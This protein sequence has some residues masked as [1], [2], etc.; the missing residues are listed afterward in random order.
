MACPDELT[1]DLWLADALPSDEA[2]AVA[3]HVDT[4][5]TCAAAEQA[6]TRSTAELHAALALDAEELAYLRAWGWPRRWRTSPAA[7]AVN[8][9]WIALAGVVA[10]FVAWWVA[11]PT[12]GFA[13]ATAAQV[14]VGTVLLNAALVFLFSLGQALFEL[15]RNPA[16]RPES[17][18][19]GAARAGAAGLAA[20]P[21]S[22]QEYT[23]MNFRFSF[24]ALVL[25]S[26]LL[27]LAVP[28]AAMAAEVR[29][30]TSAVVAPG[31]TV[32][33]DLFASGQTVTVA[34]RV[35]GDVYAIGQT[36][37][38]TGT[39][40]GDLIAAA[41]Q[42]VVDGTVNGNV[43]AAGAVDH[44]QWPSG[45]QR[46]GSGPAGQH[47]LQWPRRRQP[48]RGRRDHQ[49]VRPGRSRDHRRR[50]H[51][52]ARRASRRQR[53]GVGRQ[54]P[55]DRTE[56]AHRRQSRVSLRNSRLKF[57]AGR[58]PAGC[59]LTRSSA[60][61]R[62]EP[63]LNGLFDFGGLV[64]LLGSAILGALAII[65]APRAAARAVELGRQQPVQ[66]FGVG[67][68]A[69]C[70]VP[71]RGPADRRH[72]G[73][74]SARVRSRRAVLARAVAGLASAGP[75]RRHRAGP[76]GASRAAD[77]GAWLPWWSV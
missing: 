40:D 77:A 67:L 71:A 61:Q 20:S 66:T 48:G 62:Q 14:G 64:L 69:L 13:S 63:L 60:Q 4:C 38:V 51:A 39:V 37:V 43:R 9:G 15:S 3:G 54:H 41:Q 70:V 44:G 32:N 31:E 52:A 58:L 23:V 11:A 35:I 17:A 18:A 22:T 10:G 34:G 5:A 29:N 46:H 8:W 28:G 53:S 16:S 72:A 7:S 19:A 68:L 25:G 33:D 75:G 6:R 47:Q 59:S 65:F 2:A 74:H 12:F 76:A 49:R 50:R 45:A 42:V 1:L 27:V 55:V 57:P 56:H 30:D 21:D 36:V 24:S 26:A 73:R